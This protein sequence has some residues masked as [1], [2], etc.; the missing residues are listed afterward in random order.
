MGALADENANLA[1]NP[2]AN[3]TTLVASQNVEVVAHESEGHDG[4]SRA[5]GSARTAKS[6]A[7]SGRPAPR[8]DPRQANDSPGLAPQS[9]ASR[10]APL[11]RARLQEYSLS[12]SAS[13]SAADRE[14][15]E[16]GCK[17]RDLVRGAPSGGSPWG[18]PHR[19]RFVSA[20]MTRLPARSNCCARRWGGSN[21][22]TR[23]TEAGRAMRCRAPLAPAAFAQ[24]RLAPGGAMVMPGCRRAPCP[25]ARP[26][27]PP[28]LREQQLLGDR[29]ARNGNR[30]NLW[31]LA[32]GRDETRECMLRAQPFPVRAS[33]RSW[34]GRWR[35]SRRCSI[36]W[37]A[38]WRRQSLRRGVASAAGSSFF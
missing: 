19:E 17:H 21:P 4:P 14:R 26:R 7:A 2:V 5:R 13:H 29:A 33:A 8:G 6:D 1:V 9:P 36:S 3:E 34:L 38:R 10:P 22:L 16:Q 27:A 20:A 31:T 23:S 28:A 18:A 24:Q 32:R 35:C 30:Q 25:G 12:R 15:R 37:I 11:L